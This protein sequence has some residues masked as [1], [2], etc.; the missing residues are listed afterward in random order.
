MQDIYVLQT[1]LLANRVHRETKLMAY[2]P[3][4]RMRAIDMYWASTSH[5]VPGSQ[6]RSLQIPTTAC[7]ANGGGWEGGHR[8]KN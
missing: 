5:C 3:G 1:N 7:F 6:I 2:L 4:R 8:D